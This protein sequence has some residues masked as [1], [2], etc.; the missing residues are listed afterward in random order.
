MMIT[1]IPELIYG[2]EHI[3]KRG[4]LL[5]FNALNLESSKRFYIIQQSEAGLVRAWQGHRKEQKWFYVVEGAFK[6]VLTIIHGKD[7]KVL[8]VPGGFASGFVAINPNSKLM[9]FS[10]FQL[11]E[12][13]QDDFRFDKDMWYK[14]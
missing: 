7:I 11:E 8:H 9:V 12:S 3:D 6:I 13:L 10:D 4:S 2:S 5:F 1:G 14:W